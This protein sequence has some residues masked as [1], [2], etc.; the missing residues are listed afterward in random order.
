MGTGNL[1][2]SH[3]DRQFEGETFAWRLGARAVAGAGDPE[4]EWGCSPAAR[5]PAPTAHKKTCAMQ[6]PENS[7]SEEGGLAAMHPVQEG[8]IEVFTGVVRILGLPPSVGGIYGLFFTSPE[9]LSLDDVVGRL[10]ISKG[11]ASQGLR[12]LRTLGALR[13]S[14]HHEGRRE[15]F[16]PDTELKK[17]VSGF[18]GSQVLPE[19]ERTRASSDHLHALLDEAGDDDDLV[20]FLRERL[21]KLDSWQGRGRQVLKLLHRFLD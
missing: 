15:F 13:P 6:R 3:G 8:M 12:L 9:P 18:I 5:P 7:P 2:V 11:S 19:L 21:R 14:N 4:E 17:L 1:R 10:R 20:P 16:E